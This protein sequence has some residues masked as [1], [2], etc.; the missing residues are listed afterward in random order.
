VMDFICTCL[1]SKELDGLSLSPEIGS[2]NKL[3]SY[4]PKFSTV[5]LVSKTL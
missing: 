5:Q 3:I 4:Y 2:V 1:L